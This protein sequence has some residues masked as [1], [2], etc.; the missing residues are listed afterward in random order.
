VAGVATDNLCLRRVPGAK[1]DT[2]R[3]SLGDVCNKDATVIAHGGDIQ[4]L[5]ADAFLEQGQ[6]FGGADISL[7]NAGGV[8][9][10]IPAGDITVGKV[11]T[12]LPFKNTLYRLQLTGAQVRAAL[13][14]GIDSVL[15]GTGSGAYPYTGGLRFRWT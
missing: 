10:D 3:S 4:Q 15:N 5:V 7:Q 11:Y 13:E 9:I 6:R 14:D 8:R 12:L 1:R 2:T